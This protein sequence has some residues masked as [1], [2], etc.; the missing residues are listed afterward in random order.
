M[1]MEK[2]AIKILQN[3]S[4]IRGV[5]LE[6]VPGEAVNLT[7]DI[8]MKIGFAFNRWLKEKTGKDKVSVAVG[9]DSRLTGE[10]LAQAVC[11]GLVSGGNQ[12]Y[13]C[14]IATTPAMF[15]TTQDPE[16]DC[17]GGVMITAS[18]LPF[19]RN[20]IK[21]F[22]KEGGLNKEDIAAILADAEEVVTS[23]TA[24]GKREHWAFIP[25]Y[26]AGIVDKIR[27][28]TGSDTPLAGAKILVDAGNGAGGF[29]AKLVLQPLGADTTGS[30]FL[31][32]DGNFP[33]HIPNPEDVDAI[34]SVTKAVID[35]GADIGI[36]F[37]TDVD[38]AAIID[39]KGQAINR[40]DFIAFIASIILAKYPGTTI[41]TDSV[42]SRG[43]T[44]YIEAH[45]GVHHR[46][47]RGYKNVI[48][49]AVRLNAAGQECHLAM[50]TSGHG[51]IKENYFLDDG[52]YLVTL[53]LIKF[54]ALR[55]E[56]KLLSET[57]TD[58]KRPA[59]SQ[60]FRYKIAE[61]D[62]K[63]YGNQVLEDFKAFA[64]AHPGW[65][66][67]TP[68]YE[69]VRV[70]CD[71]NSGNGWCLLRMSLH[72]PVMPLN[73]ESDSPGGCAAIK[74]VIDEFTAKYDKLS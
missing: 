2:L 64:A 53:A 49:E 4:D 7:Q 44:A 43:L 21:L 61:A 19:N 59:E 40:D 63:A 23:F 37:D 70:D 9:R 30:Q 56:G 36:I 8:A 10:H 14:G 31:E 22:T 27:Q 57:L 60:E 16:K 50:E 3:G 62:F 55:T 71:E 65:S 35:N 17:D 67:V 28:E 52:A 51:A 15:M 12:V 32:P 34:A 5:A 66:I 72:D 11:L 24:G 33:N 26:A 1:T 54:A 25:E 69:G 29:F 39:E 45:G 58:L 42:T 18:H 41:V 74:A 38:R 73:I 20:G 46:F 48:N 6:G 68:N 47:Q 13:D